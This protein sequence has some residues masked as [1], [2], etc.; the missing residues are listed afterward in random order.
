VKA[1]RFHDLYGPPK[2]NYSAG[3]VRAVSYLLIALGIALLAS[4]A[5]DEDRGVTWVIRP[6]GRT[7][8]NPLDRNGTFVRSEDPDLFRYVM[9]YQW[10]KASLILCGGFAVLGICRRLDR[11]DPFSPDFTGNSALDECERVL[12]AELDKKHRPLR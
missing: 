6:L 11:S 7:G 12:D 9:N 8:R 10:L 5:Y 1:R 4:C 2:L 3:F